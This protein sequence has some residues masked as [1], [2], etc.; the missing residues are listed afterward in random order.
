MIAP[1]YHL[2]D[3]IQ[4][5]TFWSHQPRLFLLTSSSHRCT[6]AVGTV[7]HMTHDFIELFNRGSSAEGIAR[8]LV[9]AV[10]QRHRNREFRRAVQPRSLLCRRCTVQPGQYVLVQEAQGSGGTTALP[11]A[12]VTDASPIALSGTGGKVALANIATGLGCKRQLDAMQLGSTGID[13]GPGCWDGANFFEGAGPAPATTNT[14]A[15]L[16]SSGG[17]VDTDNNAADFTVGIPS[18]HNSGSPIKDCSLPSGTGTAAPSYLEPGDTSLLTMAV[19]PGNQSDQHRVGGHLRS[20]RD[21]RQRIPNTFQRRHQRRCD[22]FR[23]HFLLHHNSRSYNP[24]WCQESALFNHGCRG[25]H[26]ICLHFTGGLDNSPDRDGAGLGERCCRWS[27][28]RFSL[29]RSSSKHQGV[30][31]EKTLARTSTRRF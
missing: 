20:Q 2:I 15:V 7:G 3:D 21:R 24:S 19:L 11:P 23:H 1:D 31:Y 9:A 6:A 13:C 4:P 17:C 28:I 22:C 5:L 27:D 16:R 12:D 10:C 8:R 30:I 29:A 14:T 18:P 26:R 25:A